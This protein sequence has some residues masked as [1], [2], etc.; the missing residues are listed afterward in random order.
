MSRKLQAWI[1]NTFGFTKTE[2]NG[3][4]I[5]FGIM[6]VLVMVPFMID[7]L[8]P[9]KNYLSTNDQKVLDSITGLIEFANPT[10]VN[11]LEIP[12]ELFRF[13]PNDISKSDLV[14][15]GLQ[16]SVALR[17]IK[18][19][20]AGGNFRIKKDLLKIYGFSEAEY[21]QL[22]SYIDLPDRLPD[23]K[24]Y[25]EKEL[26]KKPV[27]FKSV[28]ANPVV[29][30]DINQADTSDLVAIKG[31]GKVLAT[32]IIKFR[33]LLGGF[34]SIQQLEEIYGLPDETVK[35][36]QESAYINQDYKPT[37]ININ[38]ANRS[39]L[40]K[41]PYIDPELAKK[42]IEFRDKNGSFKSTDALRDASIMADSLFNK[43]QPYVTL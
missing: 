27:E 19:R 35:I 28:S 30:L 40:L 23:K 10:S 24:P 21:D 8:V 25:N 36:L 41:H 20:E 15:L 31:I 22:K 17:L 13:N 1:R 3:T 32:R 9:G 37:Q 38:F 29:L 5:L 14:R 12:P 2:T 42:L 34:T 39:E 11:A 26:T 4:I 43:L 33:E 7:D 16:E 18:Y 6:L